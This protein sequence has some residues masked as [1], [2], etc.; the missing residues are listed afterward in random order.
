MS[1]AEGR[2]APLPFIH[3]E[4]AAERLRLSAMPN[5][6]SRRA[7]PAAPPSGAPLHSPAPSPPKKGTGV[8]GSTGVAPRSITGR[9]AVRQGGIRR[10]APSSS[11]LAPP[12]WPRT[13]T[14]A[15]LALSASCSCLVG[16]AA[17][18]LHTPGRGW[19]PAA[20]TATPALRG[21][22]RNKA[23]PLPSPLA[24]TDPRGVWN[25]PKP[26]PLTGRGAEVCFPCD[27]RAAGGWGRPIAA[28]LYLRPAPRQWPFGPLRG[29]SLSRPTP[30]RAAR[31]AARTPA[32]DLGRLLRARRLS[33]ERW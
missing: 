29:R 22:H 7:R 24:G 15:T 31:C 18:Q 9:G 32:R 17:F 26:R 21:R 27:G 20:C 13:A 19:R 11:G 4:S 14:W 2:G 28:G 5:L 16:S 25:C 33:A 3:A 8:R 6:S 30:A 10:A 23:P 1:Q 12:A